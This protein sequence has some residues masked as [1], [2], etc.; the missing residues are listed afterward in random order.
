MAE[1]HGM[2]RRER[3]A[4]RRTWRTERR[5][6]VP[7]A[8]AVFRYLSR[9]HDEQEEAKREPHTAFIPAPTDALLGL[10]RVNADVV[11]FVWDHTRHTRATLDMDATLVETHKQQALYSLAF[12]LN[13]ALKRLALGGQWVSRRLK[14]VRFGLISL[15]GRFVR[16]ARR[17]IIR[18]ASGHPSYDLPTARGRILA[19]SHGSP[20]P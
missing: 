14:A 16:H 10:R 3:R 18:L 6:S 2:H 11:G 12:N 5:R 9:F 15:A 20:L 19:L 7:S 17:L 8:S 1:S 4:L 13:S